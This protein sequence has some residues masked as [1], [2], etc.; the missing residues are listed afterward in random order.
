[1]QIESAKYKR[2]R[3]GS[4]YNICCTSGKNESAR[5][6]AMVL[7]TIGHD[8]IK[9]LRRFLRTVQSDINKTCRDEAHTDLSELHDAVLPHIIA[10]NEHI[11][12]KNPM[13]KRKPVGFCLAMALIYGN[14]LR[15]KWLGDCR[16]YHLR[17]NSDPGKPPHVTLVTVDHNRLQEVMKKEETYTFLKNEMTELSRSLTL[18][19]GKP[20]QTIIETVLKEQQQAVIEIQPRDCIL[21][22][23]DGAYLPLVRSMLDLSHFQ[24]TNEQFILEN[25]FSEFL[26][27]GGYIQPENGSDRWKEIIPDI[28]QSVEKYTGRKSRYKDDIAGIA[29]RVTA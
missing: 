3:F 27:K 22:L 17:P 18:Y 19:W 4:D 23:T 16:I 20:E 8:P 14:K 15:C 28:I 13:E 6:I 2:P 26:Y 25:Q 21:L 11:W 24:L 12:S 5:S 9:N 7:D 10:H 29:L 1:M